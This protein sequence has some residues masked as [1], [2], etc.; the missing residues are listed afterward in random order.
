M[1]I[2]PSYDKGT[3]YFAPET[4]FERMVLYKCETIRLR[5]EPTSKVCYKKW[6]SEKPLLKK[7]PQHGK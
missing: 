6:K 4:E 1:K 7:E 5:V 2:Y 3:L